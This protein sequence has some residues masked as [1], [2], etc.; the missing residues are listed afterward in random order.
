MGVVTLES[1]CPHCLRERATLEAVSEH[2]QSTA[3]RCAV[4]FMCK[5]CEDFTTVI[6]EV[7]GSHSPMASAKFNGRNLTIYTDHIRAMQNGFPFVKM[8]PSELSHNA[9]DHSPDRCAKFFIEAKENL[10]RGNYETSIMLCRKVIDIATREILG[11]DS[12]KEQLSQRISM[13]HGKGKITEQ[14]KDW[15]HIVRIDS[16][17]A[18]HSDEEFTQEEAEEMI[19][20]T[21]VFLIYSFTLPEMVRAKQHKPEE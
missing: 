9:P 15:A 18:V 5:S 20:F 13:L 10:Q 21:E 2:R 17:G 12:K 1:S 16:N 7:Y 11:E 8:Y 3:S 4:V 6:L 14:M 19:G